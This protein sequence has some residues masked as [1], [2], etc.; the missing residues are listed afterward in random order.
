MP[1]VDNR[2]FGQES[3]VNL[4]G[5]HDGDAGRISHGLADEIGLSAVPA[6]AKLHFEGDASGNIGIATFGG[7]LVV[8]IGCLQLRGPS[9]EPPSAPDGVHFT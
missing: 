7:Q 8:L 4:K 5:G 3:P 6:P 9:G 2:I 1:F